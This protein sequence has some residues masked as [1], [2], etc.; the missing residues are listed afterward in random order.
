MRL[1]GKAA[2]AAIL[3]FPLLAMS[4]DSVTIEQ[5]RWT[6]TISTVSATLNGKPV[7]KDQLGDEVTHRSICITAAEAA[8][9]A[10]YFKSQTI[11]GNCGAPTGTVGNGK[12]ALAGACQAGENPAAIIELDG[13]YAGKSYRA[14][15]RAKSNPP[16]GEVIVNMRIEGA[17]E[18]QCRG[19]E[20]NAGIE[21]SGG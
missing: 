21:P 5:G 19:D 4:A 3:A 20:D 18:G 13:S 10:L 9:P 1:F 6:E 8:D 17:H 16:A 7:P 14:D 12:M 11:G 15:I 2:T